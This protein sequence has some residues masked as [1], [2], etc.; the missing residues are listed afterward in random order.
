MGF[1]NRYQKFYWNYSTL[2]APN[3][4]VHCLVIHSS[5]ILSI[6]THG[7]LNKIK[8]YNVCRSEEKLWKKY[9]D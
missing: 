2:I 5:H 1:I 7:V 4:Y 6:R 8:N 9:K 3:F